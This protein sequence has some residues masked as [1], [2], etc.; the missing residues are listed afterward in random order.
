MITGGQVPAGSQ[1]PLPEGYGY[2]H[3][4]HREVLDR[5]GILTELRARA[6]WVVI[7]PG[8]RGPNLLPLVV[9]RP[10]VA[11]RRGLG[12]LRADGDGTLL[13]DGVGWNQEPTP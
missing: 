7:G 13:L 6:P 1:Y 2:V 3:S 9:T 8:D 5:C 4:L 10:V 11:L 12:G